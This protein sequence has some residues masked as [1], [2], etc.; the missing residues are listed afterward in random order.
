MKSIHSIGLRTKLVLTIMLAIAPVLIITLLALGSLSSQLLEAAAREKLEATAASAR[1]AVDRWDHYF[2]LA[3]EN[4]RGQP[5][6]LNMNP[7]DQKPVL[8]AMKRVYDGVDI[9]RVTRPDG[10]SVAHSDGLA[11]ISYADRAWFKACMAG[12]PI[13]RQILTTKTTGEPALN[14]SVPIFGPDGKIVGV[15]SVVTGLASMSDLLGL[16]SL[17]DDERVIVVD[18]KGIVVAQPHSTASARLENLSD[19]PPVRAARNGKG[20]RMT[21][22]DDQERVWLANTSLLKNGWTVIA[23]RAQSAVMAPGVRVMRTAAAIGGGALCIAA[24]L[25]WLVASRLVRPIRGLTAAATRVDPR[26]LVAPRAGRN[27]RRSRNLVESVQRHDRPPAIH[28]SRSRRPGRKANGRPFSI[29]GA[30]AGSVET[31]PDLILTMD[32]KGTLLYINRAEHGFTLDA[33]I[34]TSAYD[35]VR[36]E[37]RGKF[38]ECVESVVRTASPIVSSLPSTRPTATWCGIRRSMGPLREHGQVVGV[39]SVATDVTRR[40]QSDISLLESEQRFRSTFEQAAVGMAEWR[41]KVVSCRVNQTLSK[42]LGYSSEELLSRTFQD[43]TH[44]D[45]LDTDLQHMRQVLDGEIATYSME[46]RYYRKDG[47]IVWVNLTVALVRDASGARNT[48]SRSLKI[49]ASA[50]RPRKN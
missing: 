25:V 2:V 7:D 5:D 30:L 33:L 39:M 14:F 44:P 12:T 11:P 45:D 37:S 49:F 15:A 10:I 17:G 42:F 16:G 27:D 9:V 13:A 22:A 26:Q 18:E 23:Q 21:F 50:S 20:G 46:K 41:P 31:A 47:T 19:Y 35:H 36:P 40:K 4:L 29:G 28:L 34:G 43:I 48:S 3:L 8:Q 32:S 38:R 6:I 1:D 24:I